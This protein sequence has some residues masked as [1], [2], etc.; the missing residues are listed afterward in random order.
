MKLSYFKA[1]RYQSYI[2]DHF[3]EYAVPDRN[4]V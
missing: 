2:S 3:V 1:M 4:E